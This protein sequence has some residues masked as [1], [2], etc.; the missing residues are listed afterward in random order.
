MTEPND[1]NAPAAPGTFPSVIPPPV[2]PAPATDW[3]SRLLQPVAESTGWLKFLSV[4]VIA[5]GVLTA[6][7]IVGLVIAWLN[8]WVGVLLWQASERA[9]RA[10]VTRD[11]AQL[12]AY[13]QKL[14][15]LIVIAGVMLIVNLAAVLL[16]I[17]LALALGWM[18]SLLHSI[19]A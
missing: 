9:S 18:A 17:S 2:P 4:A 12:E 1:P 3:F 5:L 16:F 14:R 15:T 11:P 19:P 8:I 7:T 13:L 6:L 10:Q